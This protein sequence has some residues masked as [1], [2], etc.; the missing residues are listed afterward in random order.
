M[1]LPSENPYAGDRR[2]PMNHR[3]YESIPRRLAQLSKELVEAGYSSRLAS[4]AEL[5]QAILH[6]GMPT[7]AEESAQLLQRWAVLKAA[8]PA[9]R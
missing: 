7:S 3:V 8:P 1:E 6:F 4:Q 2:V 5:A 9:R